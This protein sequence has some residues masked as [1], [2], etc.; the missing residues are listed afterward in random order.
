MT[1]KNE[2][3]RE[4]STDLNALTHE[5]ASIERGLRGARRWLSGR[6]NEHDPRTKMARDYIAKH[7]AGRP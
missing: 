6:P 5:Q 7:E 3:P 4:A 2:T 1:P